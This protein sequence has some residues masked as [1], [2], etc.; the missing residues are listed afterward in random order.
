M[1]LPG[2]ATQLRSLCAEAQELTRP[3]DGRYLDAC[4][5]IRV[6]EQDL[7]AGTEYIPGAPPLAGV[8]API[9]V[10]GRYDCIARAFVE[11]DEGNGGALN[12]V[13]WYVGPRQAAILL[14]RSEEKTRTLLYSAEGGGKTVLMGQWLVYQ[15]LLLAWEGVGGYGGATAPTGKRLGSLVKAIRERVPIDSHLEPIP[16]AWGRYHV[17]DNEIRFRFGVTLQCRSTKKQSAATGS[18]IQGYTW[19]FS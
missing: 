7:A 9:R 1:A 3:D 18:P 15:S 2:P 11:P 5:E 17:A 19:R 6:V 8:E 16:G 4:I 14:D 13:V 12:P 10:G